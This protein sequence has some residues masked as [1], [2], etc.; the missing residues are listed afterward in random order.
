MTNDKLRWVLPIPFL[1]LGAGAWL[2][3][4]TENEVRVQVDR[5][6]AHWREGDY[7]RSV[8]LYEFV[9]ETYPKSRYA[10]DVLW[11]IANIYYV[12]FHDVDRALKFF[13]TLVAL[14]P[15]GVR[16]AN[17]YLKLA[18]IHEVELNDLPQAI[19]YLSQILKLGVGPDFR[20]R[21]HF[22][23][24]SIYLKL[25]QFQ[26]AL[27][28]LKFLAQ[29]GPEDHLAQQSRARVGKIFQI[30][31]EFEQSI[32]YFQE[33][34]DYTDCNNCRVE[35]HLGLI[36]SYE[37]LGELQ[38]AIEAAQAIPSPSYPPQMKEDLLKR[39]KNKLQY[40]RPRQ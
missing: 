23:F 9:Y 26:E 6:K 33:V 38:K 27:L 35:A 17:A 1:I 25:N 36:E 10:E 20:R 19:E 12:N 7:T 15:G 22:R 29:G 21:L 14:Y 2:Y 28:H 11:E 4:E 18:E 24:G 5:A 8:K 39:L 13:R 40:Y 32:T 3:F 31:R 37:F 34:L 30:Q 16:A